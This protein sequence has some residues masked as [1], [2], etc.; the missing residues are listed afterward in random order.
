MANKILEEKAIIDAAAKA[1]EKTYTESEVREIL[2][3]FIEEYTHKT[4]DNIA[5]SYLRDLD[6]DIELELGYDNR[7][8]ASIDASGK[9]SDIAH[10]VEGDLLHLAERYS[11]SDALEGVS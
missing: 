5:D 4:V 10:D 8:I 6:D 1:Q 9:A 2:K 11:L 3:A 7:I